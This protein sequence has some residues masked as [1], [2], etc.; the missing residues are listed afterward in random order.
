MTKLPRLTAAWLAQAKQRA[1][2]STGARGQVDAEAYPP[3]SISRTTGAH[4]PNYEPNAHGVGLVHLGVGNFHRAHQAV[5]TDDVLAN[6]GG[7]WRILGVSLRSAAAADAMNPQDG[8]Y[9]LLIRG[10]RGTEARVVGSIARVVAAARGPGPVWAALTNPRTRVV[11]LT[12][13]EKAYGIDRASGQVQLQH[14][15]I[16]HDIACP[17]QPAG[18]LGM[19]V[20]ALRRRRQRRLAPFTV[21]CCDNLPENGH[22]LSAGVCDMADRVEPGLGAWIASH[23]AFPCSMVDRITPASTASTLEDA[24]RATGCED[25]AAVETEPFSMWVVEDRFP[26]G[27]PAWDEAGAL[28]VGDVAPYEHMKLRM[29][30]GAHSLLAYAGHVAGHVYVRDAMRDKALSRRVDDYLHSAAATLQ[31]LPGFDLNDYAAALRQRFANPAIA[32]KTYQIAMDGTEKLPQRI[33]AP[34]QDCLAGRGDTYPFALAT[35]AWMRYCLG[36]TDNGARYDLRDPRADEIAAAV[37]GACD[38]LGRPQNAQAV[39]SALMALPGLFPSALPRSSVWRRQVESV[40]EVMLER[41]MDAALH[42]THCAGPQ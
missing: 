34:A 35:A 20:W 23:V 39:S 1:A 16:A 37:R 7:D 8:L 13:T 27:R 42:K 17:D 38:M 2:Q 3:G 41:G 24:A 15:G 31:P 30:N 6:R 19:L 9:T 12:V 29:L 26:S 11:T 32:H 18:V 10:E 25:W 36:V 5:Y 14:P 40:L 22:L 28:M 33:L 21:L 4:L